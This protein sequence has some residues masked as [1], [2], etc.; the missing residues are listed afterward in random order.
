MRKLHYAGG[1]I[2]ISDQVCKAVL[3]YARALSHSDTSDL[4]I[5]P[6][7]TEEFGRGVAHILIGPASQILSVPTADLEIDL[8]DSRMVEIL[9]SRTKELD[10]QRPDW[11]E[12]VADVMDLDQYDWGM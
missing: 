9:E 4:V 7:F 5:L 8:A 3:R 11:D 2:I 6:S 1:S 10:P 12:D